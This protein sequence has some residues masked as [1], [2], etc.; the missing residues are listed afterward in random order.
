M[1]QIGEIYSDRYAIE[2]PIARGGMADVFLAR[3]RFLDRPVAVKILFP[4]FA[5]DPSFVERFRREAQSAAMLNHPNIVGV[6]D[7]GQERG[8]YFIVM[9][10]VEGQSLRDII[11]DEGPLPTMARLGSRPRSPA[12]S[13]SRTDMAS[14]T[15]TSS[16]ATCSS[17]SRVR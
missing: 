6:Y 14:C 3:D 15:A 5:R 10:Y 17:R 12:R 11:R 13:T 8:T 2:R 7:Y 9:E 1:T 16:P 4:E